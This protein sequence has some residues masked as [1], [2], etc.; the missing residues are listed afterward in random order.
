MGL[1]YYLRGLGVGIV[2]TALIM[3]IATSVNSKETL[4]DKEIRERAKE[5]G[6]VEESTVLADTFAQEN[7]NSPQEGEAESL[8]RPSSQKQEEDS[9]QNKEESPAPKEEEAE[10]TSEP[11]GN[12]KE[13]KTEKEAKPS[14]T[15]KATE[16]P[17]QASAPSPSAP[18]QKPTAAPTA[19]PTQKPTAA[20]T[21]SPAQ[22][23]ETAPSPTSTPKEETAVQEA[24]P[25]G[26]GESVK[27]EIVSGDSSVTV[28]KKLAQAGLV[29]SANEYD[30]FLCQN[31][32]DKRI[33]AGSFEIPVGAKEEEI[34]EIITK[35]GR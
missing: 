28:C 35:T 5:L 4:S 15:P 13:N 12:T 30:S 20:P 29:E 18:T 1:K 8:S 26:Q 19:S 25:A 14:Q 9:E 21:S 33:R 24:S 34:A 31:G 3:G 11:S 32:Y 6:M 16:E 22:K 17:A 10:E 27:I 23:P 2:V 7:V